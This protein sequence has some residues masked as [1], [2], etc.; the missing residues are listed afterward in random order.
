MTSTDSAA[1]K[2]PAKAPAKDPWDLPDVSGLVV[3]VLGGTGPQGKGLAYRLAKA[4]QKV[5]VGSR[6]AERAAAAAEEIGHGVEGADNAETARRSDVVI[7]AVPWDGHGKTLE[8]LRAELS[9]KLVVDCV[10]PLGFDKKGAY[11][12]KPEEGSAAEQAAALLPDSRVAAAFHHLSAVL[13]QDP[14]IDEI[15]TDVMVLGE[16]RA[17]VEIVQALAGRIPGMR[18]VFAGRLRNAHQV[19]SLVANLISVNRRYKAHAGLRVTDV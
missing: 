10:N 18:G 6:A 4:G 17:D 13:L 15:D 14:E 1:Q 16:E 7:V 3:G 19:E 8:S 11:A 2:A 12:L 9:G 5:I